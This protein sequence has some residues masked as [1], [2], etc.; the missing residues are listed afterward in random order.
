MG[1]SIAMGKRVRPR[2][3]FDYYLTPNSL[4]CACLDVLPTELTPCTIL[5]PGAGT[6]VWG[7]AARV[8]YPHSRIV[9]C[10]LRLE[11]PTAS[12]DHWRHGDFLAMPFYE[13]YELII[14]NPPYDRAEAFVRKS[15]DLLTPGGYLLLLLRLG[16]LEGQ[17]RGD[18]LWIEYPPQLVAVCSAR[19]SFT[20]D[21]KTDATAYAC[22][23]WQEGERPTPQLTW[24]SHKPRQLSLL[25]L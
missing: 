12:Y 19:P 7:D 14:G 13:S 10:E 1:M 18:A 20:G 24:I 6:G 22:F 11:H 23:L 3:S 9:G 4:C 17:E 21:S 8:R 15:L 5:D 2:T 16:F 25:A